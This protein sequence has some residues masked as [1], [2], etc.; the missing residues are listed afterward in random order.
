MVSGTPVL[1]TKLPCFPD[2]YLPYLYLFHEETVDGMYK[3]LYE[4]LSLD[5]EELEEKGK[6]CRDF[7][8]REKNNV[9]QSKRILDLINAV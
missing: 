6:A 3:D 8:L 7:V 2:E 4:V 9:V 1:T 5:N